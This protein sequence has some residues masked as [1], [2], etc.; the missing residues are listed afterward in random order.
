MKLTTLNKWLRKIGLIFV[1]TIDVH[2]FA[3]APGRVDLVGISFSIST[4]K[5][6]DRRVST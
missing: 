5:A 6:Y 3:D 4:A 1:V 2:T